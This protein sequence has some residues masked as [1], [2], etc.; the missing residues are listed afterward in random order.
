MVSTT[1]IY[2]LKIVQRIEM[3]RHVKITQLKLDIIHVA[4]TLH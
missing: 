3:K 1:N 2:M 4:A